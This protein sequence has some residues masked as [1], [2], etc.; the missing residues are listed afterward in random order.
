M[1]LATRFSINLSC[2]ILLLLYDT[3][4]SLASGMSYKKAD[5]GGG[6]LRDKGWVPGLKNLVKFLRV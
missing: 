2:F 6:D 4:K 5:W 3:D 1:R